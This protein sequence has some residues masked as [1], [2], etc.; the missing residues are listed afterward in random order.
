MPFA[1]FPADR[2][3]HVDNLGDWLIDYV[4]LSWG[5]ELNADGK[6]VKLL[7]RKRGLTL[8]PASEGAAPM[9]SADAFAGHPAAVFTAET[10]R[11]GASPAV[12]YPGGPCKI[13]FLGHWQGADDPGVTS[14]PTVTTGYGVLWNGD[15]SHSAS[16]C[17][18]ANNENN[19]VYKANVR[20]AAGGAASR[21]SAPLPW[22]DPELIIGTIGED[23]LEIEQAGVTTGPVE[24]M[25]VA[26][27]QTSVSFGNNGAN[28]SPFIGPS[29]GYYIT[30]IDMPA[31]LELALRRDI[32]RRHPSL[33][34]GGL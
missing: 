11:L 9:W 8:T 33:T 3:F 2:G 26:P 18:Q 17:A 30:R 27:G 10:S 23:T 21:L 15:S 32:A 14:G 28:N 16:I 13:W 6:I 1:P 25:I 5:Y 22:D 7:T 31:P 34:I 20:C 4:D 29:A 12:G 24:R 19:G